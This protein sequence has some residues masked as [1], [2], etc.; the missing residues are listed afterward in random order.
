M[1]I[2]YFASHAYCSHVHLFGAIECGLNCATNQRHTF[3]IDDNGHLCETCIFLCGAMLDPDEVPVQFNPPQ[4]GNDELLEWDEEARENNR[5]KRR[6]DMK[7]IPDEWTVES[8]GGDE[9][10]METEGSDD[11]AIQ[12]GRVLDTYKLTK[13]EFTNRKYQR[14]WWGKR[15]R[16]D[17]SS[18]ERW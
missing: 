2:T 8:A 18:I 16:L 14:M 9:W 6:M 4:F 17:K 15:C 11:L 10:E 13:L 3:H 12:K 7:T 5:N 1:C